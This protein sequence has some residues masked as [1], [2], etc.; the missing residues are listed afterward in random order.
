MPSLHVHLRIKKPGFSQNKLEGNNFNNKTCSSLKSKNHW[1]ETLQTF[2]QRPSCQKH[3]LILAVQCFNAPNNIQYP[4]NCGGMVANLRNV[5]PNTT[6]KGGGEMFII[7]REWI[8]GGV[9]QTECSNQSCQL[10]T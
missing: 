2:I 7:Y 9:S 1:D 6:L 3:K 5:S 4:V 8:R 10:V